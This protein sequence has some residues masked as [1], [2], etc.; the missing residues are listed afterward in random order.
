M[1][2]LHA[3]EV[4]LGEEHPDYD[5]PDIPTVVSENVNFVIGQF[6][7]SFVVNLESSITT[8]TVPPDPFNDLS[9]VKLLTKL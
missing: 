1:I 8:L 2:V 4:S 3:I 7:L 9:N 5:N 6:I